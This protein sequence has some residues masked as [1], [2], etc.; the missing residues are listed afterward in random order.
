MMKISRWWGNGCWA[1]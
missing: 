1:I